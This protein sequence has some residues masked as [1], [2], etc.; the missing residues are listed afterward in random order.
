VADLGVELFDG[1][2]CESKEYRAGTVDAKGIGSGK[3]FEFLNQLW[4]I[5]GVI[6]ILV[7]IPRSFFETNWHFKIPWAS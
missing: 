1:H 3:V 7:L 4:N 6:G 5:P 2:L